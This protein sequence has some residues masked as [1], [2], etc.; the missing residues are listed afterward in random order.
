VNKKPEFIGI[1]NIKVLESTSKYITFTAEALFIN[2]NDVGGEIQTDEIKIFVNENEMSTV[3]TELFEVPA[4]KEFSIP[5]K[6]NIPTDSLFSNKSIGGLIGSLFSKKIKVQYKG[7]I[8]YKVFGFSST[9][10]VDKTEDI[11]I[12]L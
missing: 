10:A 7:D 3:S 9:Y 5:L 4:K 11:K 6:A 12:K 1:E 2:P 8:K